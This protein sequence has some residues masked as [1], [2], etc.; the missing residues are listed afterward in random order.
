MTQITHQKAPR[1][2]LRQC[3]GELNWPA[4]SPDPNPIEHLWRDLKTVGKRNP[5][6]LRDLEQL[7]KEEWSK[8]AGEICQNLIDGYRKQLNFSYFF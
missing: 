5:L 6:N 1:N 2:G 3:A 7:A 8:T 4:M